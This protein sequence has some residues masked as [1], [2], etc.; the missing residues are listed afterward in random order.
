MKSSLKFDLREDNNQPIIKVV[1]EDSEDLRDKVARK[2]GETIGY[3]S[4]F[5]WCMFE[6]NTEGKKT[7]FIEPVKDTLEELEK[8]KAA[9]ENAIKMKKLEK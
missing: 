7:M 9:I 5:A 4:L 3:D 8:M 2:F 6:N 1:I